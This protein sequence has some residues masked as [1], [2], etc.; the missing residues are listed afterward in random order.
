MPRPSLKT[1]R[2]REILEAYVSCVAQFGLEGATQERIAREAGVARPL[3]RHNLGNREDM[4]AAL[5]QHVAAEFNSMTD[6]IA[7]AAPTLPA[8][9]EIVFDPTHQTDAR[10]NLAF[11]ALSAASAGDPSMR[12][13][14]RDCLDRYVGLIAR[15]T[16]EAAPHLPAA[17]R[18]AIAQGVSAISMSLD[19]IAPLEPPEAWRLAAKRAALRLIEP[20]TTPPSTPP[21]PSDP[22]SD[23]CA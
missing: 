18:D 9:I 10:L 16:F 19:A 7:A 12:A 2:R 21:P 1:Q 4:V 11:Q 20:A 8:L 5:L 6:Q 17:E 13:P 22:P 15:L 3:L 14:L 23:G